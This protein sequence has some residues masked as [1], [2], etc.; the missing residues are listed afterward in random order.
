MGDGPRNNT[1]VVKWC[2]FKRLIIIYVCISRDKVWSDSS[3][4]FPF[5]ELKDGTSILIVTRGNNQSC[6]EGFFLTDS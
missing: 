4:A 6:Y 3:F 1:L 2:L 5:E